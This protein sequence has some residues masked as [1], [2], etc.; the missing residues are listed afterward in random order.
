MPNS[1]T[2]SVII[3]ILNEIHGLRHLLPQLVLI[4]NIREIIVV[5]DGSVDGSQDFV[6]SFAV[7]DPRIILL[8]RQQRGLGSAVRY[9][10]QNCTASYAIIMDGDGQHR[11]QDLRTLLNTCHTTTK[12]DLIII[13]SRFLPNSTIHGFPVHRLSFSKLLNGFL[14]LTIRNS[15]SDP[16]SGFFAAP[17]PLIL[18]TETNGFKILYEILLKSP[19]NPPIDIPIEFSRRLGGNSKAQLLELLQ[20]IKTIV[21]CY[22]PRTSNQL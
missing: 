9:G 19:S 14:K 2:P 11:V 6:S 12:P 1:M 4:K 17:L 10:A 22:R 16:L 5:D 21:F 20:L 7:T 15:T 13:G 8:K 18:K 3:P